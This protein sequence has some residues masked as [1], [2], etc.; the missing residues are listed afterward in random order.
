MLKS[1]SLG[2]SGDHKRISH[3]KQC[4]VRFLPTGLQAWAVDKWE[5]E[6]VRENWAVWD[7]P[8][9]FHC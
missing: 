1:S 3:D 2:A 6:H 5:S 4:I 8:G 7:V 9:G